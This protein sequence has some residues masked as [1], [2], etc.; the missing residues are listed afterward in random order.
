MK[1][2]LQRV[3]KASVSVENQVIGR[4]NHGLVIFLGV[5]NDDTEKDANY[6]SEKIVNLRIFS[7]DQGKFN[8]SAIEVKA[9]ILVISQ[10]TLHA[11]YSKG[12]TSQL[13]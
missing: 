1:A 7:D 2:L 4:I 13:H 12:K 3:S 9:E 5:G 10:F 6:L 11:K 8:I